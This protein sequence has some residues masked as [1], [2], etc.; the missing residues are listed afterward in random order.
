MSTLTEVV[1]LGGDLVIREWDTLHDRE[2]FIVNFPVGGAANAYSLYGVPIKTLTRVGDNHWSCV[3]ILAGDEAN[4]KGILI[5]AEKVTVAA[6]A[7]TTKKYAG[8]ARGPVVI[9]KNKIADADPA[10][11]A[12]NKATIASALGA[13]GIVVR[14]EPDVVTV[15]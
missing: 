7:A 11:G 6:G 4:A 2:A 1:R 12:Y 3:V 15:G 8:I 5:A 14:A 13:L 10:G 9:N